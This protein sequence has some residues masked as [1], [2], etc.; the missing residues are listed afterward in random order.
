MPVTLGFDTRYITLGAG[1]ILHHVRGAAFVTVTPAAS[2]APTTSSFAVV[3]ATDMIAGAEKLRVGDIVQL[4]SVVIPTMTAAEVAAL[5]AVLS[6]VITG[7]NTIVTLDRPL[8]AAPAAAA[9]TVRRLYRNLGASD[10]D[11]GI[12]FDVTR[13]EQTIDQSPFVVAAPVTGISAMLMVPLVEQRAT[14]LAIALGLAAPSTDTALGIGSAPTMDR[15]D[16]FVLVCPGP[17]GLTQYWVCHRGVS[18]GKTSIKASKSSKSLY[19]LNITLMPDTLYDPNG[20]VDMA[21]A[22]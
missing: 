14:N 2:P 13:S 19:D 8:S 12:D 22:N 21:L 17:N 15:E 6:L 18:A 16:R 3:T 11:M 7:A 20:V 9:G 1:K 10:G 4:S 5:P